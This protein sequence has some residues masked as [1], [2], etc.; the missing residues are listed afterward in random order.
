MV[1]PGFLTNL[2][3]I[4]GAAAAEI[5][6]M[7]G[8]V[9]FGAEDVY[10]YRDLVHDLVTLIPQSWYDWS[11]E[12]AVE[13]AGNAKDKVKKALDGVKRLTNSSGDENSG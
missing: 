5:L 13:V 3:L 1:R 2:A 6:Q 12:K 7:M 10:Q 4:A 9:E 11:K 8:V